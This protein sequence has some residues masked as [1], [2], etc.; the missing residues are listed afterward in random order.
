[1]NIAQ[2]FNAETFIVGLLAGVLGV[3]VALLILIPGNALIHSLTGNY[4]VSAAL[5]PIGGVALVIISVVLTVI[6]GLIPS[7]KAA[8]KDPVAALRSE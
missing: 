1:M 5:P 7:G 3:A 6:G 2:V 4:D 8:R